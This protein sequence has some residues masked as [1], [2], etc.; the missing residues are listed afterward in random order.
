MPPAGM[1]NYTYAF[2]EAGFIL[3]ADFNGTLP[4]VD[5]ESITGLDGA[6]LRMGTSEHQGMDGAYIDA[7][8]MSMRTIV[9]T[10]TLYADVNNP[11]AVCNILKAQY[12]PVD[13][14]NLANAIQKFYFQ[15]P[16]QPLKFVNGQGGGCQYSID[17]LRRLGQSAIQLTVLCADPF[18]YDAVQGQDNASPQAGQINAN[19]DFEIGTTPWQPRNGATISSAPLALT[20]YY[21]M[22]MTGNGATATPGVNSEFMSV[23]PNGKYTAKASAFTIAAYASGVQVAIQWYTSGLSLISTSTGTATATVASTWLNLSLNATAPG[24][25][26]FAVLIVQAV[27]TPASTIQFFWDAVA[28]TSNPGTAFPASFSAAGFGGPLVVALNNATVYNN[29]N[30]TAYPIFTIKGP[31]I[32]PILITDALTSKSMQFNLA[33]VSGDTLVINCRNKSIVLNGKSSRNVLLGIFWHSV[34][35]ASSDTFFIFHG[36]TP[37][38]FTSGK[39]HIDL[40]STYY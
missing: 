3:N 25:A 12:G 22:L 9:I 26:A 17:T 34:P 1:N 5:V 11:D 37:Q 8:F 27:G 28:L 4:F 6:P 39:L 18:V 10:G 20:G 19:S 14:S 15:H 31:M 36:T 32:S 24:T 2:G 23:I 38:P 40:F 30:H 21:S 7:T 13:P 35:P 33:L 29:G 16:G